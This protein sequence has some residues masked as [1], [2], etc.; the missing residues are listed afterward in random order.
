MKKLV[1]HYASFYDFIIEM[2]VQSQLTSGLLTETR[3]GTLT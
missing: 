2:Y 3:F 1:D